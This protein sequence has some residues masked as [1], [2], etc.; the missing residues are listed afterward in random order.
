[1]C[2]S[3]LKLLQYAMERDAAAA[4]RTLSKHVQDCVDHIVAAGLIGRAAG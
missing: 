2:S 4:E 1:M 3:D